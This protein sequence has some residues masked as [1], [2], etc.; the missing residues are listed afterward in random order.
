VISAAAVA[1]IVVALGPYAKFIPR[2]ALAGL[3][4]LTA[5][6]MVNLKD[7]RYHVRASR[8]DAV[9]VS[10]TAIAAFAI[11]IEFCVLIGVIMSFLLAV[12]RA[13]NMLLTEFIEADADH[14]RE[15]LPEDAASP[16]IL[17]LGL[18]GELFF[19]SS[20]S[21]EHH[22]ERIEERVSERT[23]VVLMRM[24]RARNPDAVGM[25]ALDGLFERLRARGVHVLLCGVRPEMHKALKRCGLLEKLHRD[26]V[27]L[28]QPVRQTSTQAAMRF[29]RGL[30]VQAV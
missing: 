29:A 15:R 22:I 28:E 11:S 4:I 21:L 7:L 16:E 1:L 8:F 13:G 30:C 26:H 12:P 10:V 5:A 25:S 3:L 20:V 24:K 27:F 23:K 19:G 6:R 9:I 14:V 18:E 2:S 17:I